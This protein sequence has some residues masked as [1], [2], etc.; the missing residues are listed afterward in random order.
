MPVLV[1]VV[2]IRR[3]IT[4]L[5]KVIQSRERSWRRP[6]INSCLASESVL[7]TSECFSKDN[8]KIVSVV[9]V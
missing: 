6:L 5:L 9:I 3:K 7:V 8:D 4:W 1:V 2:V